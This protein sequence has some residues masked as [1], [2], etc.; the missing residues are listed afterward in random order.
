G[1]RVEVPA[2]PHNLKRFSE[3]SKLVV[4]THGADGMSD[5][6]F[7]DYLTHSQ[8]REVLEILPPHVVFDSAKFFMASRVWMDVRDFGYKQVEQFRMTFIEPPT[9]HR[10]A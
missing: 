7:W 4:E 1:G 9:T 5:E 8:K 3:G 10:R 6:E 2:R